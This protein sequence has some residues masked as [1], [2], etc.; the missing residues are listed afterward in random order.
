[1]SPPFL[2]PAARYLDRYF[3][4]AKTSRVDIYLTN[5]VKSVHGYEKP[6]RLRFQY[7]ATSLAV[8]LLFM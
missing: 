6:K 5:L 2:G 3:R 7:V 4:A 1:V 8:Q